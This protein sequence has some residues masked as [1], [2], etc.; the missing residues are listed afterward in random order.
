MHTVT[1]VAGSFD[2]GFLTED[3]TWSFTFNQVGEFEYFCMP[4]PWM[5][6]KIIVE[7]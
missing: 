3:A 2:S 5:R 7:G 4:H 6:A 1:A